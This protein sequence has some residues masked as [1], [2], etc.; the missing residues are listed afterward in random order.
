[1]RAGSVCHPPAPAPCGV[2]SFP[3][4]LLDR[5]MTRSAHPMKV[6]WAKLAW[7]ATVRTGPLEVAGV[8]LIL[9]RH[10]RSGSGSGKRTGSLRLSRGPLTAAGTQRTSR[11]CEAS[12][13]R[14]YGKMNLAGLRLRRVS[15]GTMGSPTGV[16]EK[17]WRNGPGGRAAVVLIR[18]E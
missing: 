10:L 9:R 16:E 7:E 14:V 6:A 2:W 1:M 18:G 11:S 3:I 15:R 13:E 8:L 17:G 5:W 12:F 4:K